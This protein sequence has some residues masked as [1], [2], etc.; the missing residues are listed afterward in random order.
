ML[1]CI[2]SN[3][4]VCLNGGQCIEDHCD[5]NN[6]CFVGNQCETSYNVIDLP[7]PSAILQDY[8][9]THTIYIIIITIL[10]FIAF[11]NNIFALV[12]LLR[13]R[14][15]TTICGVYII[16]FSTC[17]LILMCFF[18]TTALTVAH[19]DSIS[20]RIWSCNIIPSISLTLG[21]TSIWLSVGISIEKVL[22]ECFNFNVSG[23]RLRAIISSIGFFILAAITN[24]ANIFVRHYTI[25]PSG[26][27]ICIYDYLSNPTWDRFNKVFCYIHII[28]PITIH[29]ICSICILTTIARRKILIQTIN[30]SSQSLCHVWI[31]QLYDHRDFFIPPLCMILFVFPNS[32]YGNLLNICIPYSDV[33]KLRL[34]I[35]F[36]FLLHG[37]IVFTFIIYIYP[38]EVYLREFQ[39]TC[40][41]RVL[42]CWF[43]KRRKAKE[44]IERRRRASSMVTIQH[45]II[46]TEHI[47]KNLLKLIFL[48]YIFI[49]KKYFG[50]FSLCRI[51]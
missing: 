46:E 18:Q 28:V 9:S 49:T 15:R 27:P 11:I 30:R 23:S 5:C 32:I 4:S 16:I 48:Y 26:Y 21:Y 20:Y 50:S 19:Y 44:L 37:P 8:S 35:A 12:T 39:E 43:Y 3:N 33:V 10:V 14:I 40:L 38:S 24:L 29:L 36:V 7:F 31:R 22:I 41:Y 1:S 6:M 25:D 34:H 13:E 51:R 47:L 42:C 17:S 2:N 45:L